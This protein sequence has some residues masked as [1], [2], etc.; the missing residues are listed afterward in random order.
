V[1]GL[2]G[3]Q[4]PVVRILLSIPRVTRINFEKFTNNLVFALVYH[5]IDCDAEVDDDGGAGNRARGVDSIFT[6][7]VAEFE[8]EVVCR[9]ELPG[10]R[11]TSRALR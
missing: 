7:S 9:N 3:T 1:L 5:V 2:Y 4:K 10:F 8:H 6:G 11:C